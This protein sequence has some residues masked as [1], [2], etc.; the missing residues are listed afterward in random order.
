MPLKAFT[1][2]FLEF[3]QESLL[4]SNYKTV[5]SGRKIK[6]YIQE[7][8]NK[9]IRLKEY[10]NIISGFAFKSTDYRSEGVPLIRISNIGN[11]CV[12]KNI[13]F[14]PEDYKIHYNKF[15]LKKDDIIISLTGDGKLKGNLILESNKYLFNQRIGCLRNKK[16]INTFFL[17]YLINYSSLLKEQFYF[18]SSGKTQ[19]NISPFDFLNIK[20]PLIS[21]QK[22]DQIIALIEPIEK[23]IK[24]LKSQ[25][26]E[27]QKIINKIFAREFGFDENLYN[28][29]GKGMT[30]GTQIAQSRKLKVFEVDFKDLAKSKI[31]RFSTRFHNPS[32]KKLMNL[33]DNIDTLQIKDIVNSCEK[34]IQPHY[35][36]NGEVPVVKIANLKNNYIDFTETEFIT[37][38]S[39]S[40]LKA[41]KKLKSGDIIICVT[42]KI[43]LGKIDYYD[44]K[45]E[46]ITT[47]DN[48]IIRLKDNYNEL[49]FTYFFR[50]ILGYFQIERDFTGATNQIHLYWRQIAEFKIPNIT[51][52]SQQKVV[53]KIKSELNKQEEI[54]NKIESERNNIDGI[55]EK[56]IH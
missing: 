46:S 4:R 39:Y 33:L 5:I 31:L 22:Q 2:D 55:I 7:S 29:L 28:E 23:E 20:I 53:D 3:A 27:P 47:I 40:N 43:S 24:S 54:K 37:A 26:K 49:F 16:Q 51:L 38:T 13:V 45:Q 14:L 50:S 32:T 19:L 52:E 9:F 41:S 15:L 18:F 21:K 12:N 36:S 30:A 34:G 56:V 11:D 44:Y 10:C 48:Y 8:T 1:V 42:G 6:K 17:Y 25:I 35:D